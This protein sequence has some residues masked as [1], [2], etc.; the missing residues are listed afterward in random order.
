MANKLGED[1]SSP[2]SLFIRSTVVALF[3]SDALG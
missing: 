2:N 1:F 3:D